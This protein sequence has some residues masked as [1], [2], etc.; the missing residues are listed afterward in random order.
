MRDWW[1]DVHL[2]GAN[3][4]MPISFFFSAQCQFVDDDLDGLKM[5]PKLKEPDHSMY[6]SKCERDIKRERP[7][8]QW[9][10]LTFCDAFCYES[11]MYSG[12]YSCSLCAQDCDSNY[13]I[14]A[15]IIGE[16]LGHFCS[17]ACERSFFDL[18]KFCKF[19]RDISNSTNINGFCSL[20]CQMRYRKLYGSQ[21][22]ATKFCYQ[23]NSQTTCNIS[24]CVDGDAYQFCSFAC[25]FHLKTSNGLMPGMLNVWLEGI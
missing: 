8:F 5:A 13:A 21:T 18:M 22:D 2:S 4:K 24:L 9:E 14:H 3:F 1:A 20:D 11:C 25:Y 19:C 10:F 12:S 7:F 6:C 23:C 17:D 15:H 16:R